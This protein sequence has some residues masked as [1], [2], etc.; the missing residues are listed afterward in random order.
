MGS[1]P[2]DLGVGAIL[3]EADG[4]GVVCP[5]AFFSKRLNPY[6]KKYSTITREAL[7]LVLAVKHV[8]VRIRQLWR[9]AGL[10]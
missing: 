5:I 3:L 9:F 10:H 7:A 8:E 6:Q 1:G 2:S 4:Q